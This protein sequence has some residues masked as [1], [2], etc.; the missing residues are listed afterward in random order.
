MAKKKAKNGST[1]PKAQFLPANRAEPGMWLMIGLLLVPVMVLYASFL[2]S[3]QMLFGSDTMASLDARTLYASE[4]K[5][6]R[7]PLWFPTRLSGMPTV[8]D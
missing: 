8:D 3:D 5:Q 7:F 1:P 2:F 6:G 4:L